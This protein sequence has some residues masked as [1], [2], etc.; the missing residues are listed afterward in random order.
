MC[1]FWVLTAGKG[2]RQE[3]LGP[4]SSTR[5]RTHTQT[6]EKNKKK[7]TRPKQGKETRRQ[8]VSVC[9]PFLSF[10]K[11]KAGRVGLCAYLSIH[12]VTPPHSKVTAATNSSLPLLQARRNVENPLHAS[13]DCPQQQ[14]RLLRCCGCSR[15]RLRRYDRSKKGEAGTTRRLAA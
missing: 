11:T 6:I 13:L 10:T 2:E 5:R 9:C 12:T 3:A 8:A 4:S 15:R 7:Q 14:A 1:M